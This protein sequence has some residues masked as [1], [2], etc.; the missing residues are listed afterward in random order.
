M[1]SGGGGTECHS[2]RARLF[3]CHTADGKIA[4]H[5]RQ[6]AEYGKHQAPGAGAGVER[7]RTSWQSIRQPGF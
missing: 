6:A 7:N 1:R 2:V 4:L 5:V 3:E